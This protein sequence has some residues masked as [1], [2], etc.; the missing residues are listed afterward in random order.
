M[1]IY[2]NKIFKPYFCMFL[3]FLIKLRLIRLAV[4]INQYLVFVHLNR[5]GLKSVDCILVCPLTKIKLALHV[6]NS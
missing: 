4:K 2:Q 6:Q 5:Y 3:I 1:F